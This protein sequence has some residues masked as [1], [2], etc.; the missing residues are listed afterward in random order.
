MSASEDQ[1]QTVRRIPHPSLGL[2]FSYGAGS[3][4]NG[5]FGAIGGLAMFYYNQVVGVPA[6]LVGLA[7]SL[8][9]FID[10][11]WDPLI[12]HGSDQLR[13]RFGRRHPVFMTGLFILPLAIYL[14]WHPP[15]GWQADAMFWY[16][17][18]T[19]LFLNLAWS[20]YE[21]PTGALAAELAPDY[22]DRTLLLG[23]RWALGTM[24]AGIATLLVYGVFLRATP[25]HPVGQLNG[26]GYGPL[27]L[28]IIALIMFSGLTLTLGT[29]SKIPVLFKRAEEEAPSL[30]DQF[31]LAFSTL[32]NRNF[33]VAMSAGLIAGLSSGVNNGL[34]LYFQTF[35][36]ELK[37]SDIL[38]LT[39][40]GVPIPILGGFIAPLLS[41]RWGKK[42]T[43]MSLF[44]ASVVIGQAPMLLKLLGLLDLRGSPWLLVVLGSFSLV[45]G[46][47]SIGGYIIVSSMITDIV[48]D[49]QVK[50]GARAEGLIATADSIPNKIVN[51]ASAL[52]P[53]LLLGYVAFP[54][55]AR[56]G[57]EALEMI[58]RV[59]WI[60]LPLI[61][62]IY[63]ASISVWSFYR[64]EKSDHD[65]NLEHLGL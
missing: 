12:G 46:V 62:L 57:P 63:L 23:Y 26:A 16:I 24:G 22:H 31:G 7:I 28:S 49:V 60:Y 35:L 14:R 64:L 44:V 25:D 27:S 36:W 29:W 61:S 3:I 10:G 13:T 55:Q 54:K 56:P 18:G 58:T 11:F 48:E 15:S 6:T 53:A 47:C 9:V 45:A 37:S 52:I 65:R 50:T 40:L 38:V 19:G 4:A 32:K 30:K 42:G 8:V 2:K 59:A 34:A 1:A 21:I 33:L 51:A 39:L 5:A 41:R 17:L 20:L 43:M